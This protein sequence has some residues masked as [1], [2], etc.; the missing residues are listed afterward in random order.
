[1][2]EHLERYDHDPGWYQHPKGTVARLASGED[3]RRD[4]IKV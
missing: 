1:V 3:L 2:R 4:G